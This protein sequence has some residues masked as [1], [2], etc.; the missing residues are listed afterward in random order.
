[1]K[2]HKVDGLFLIS[3]LNRA[4]QVGGEKKHTKKRERKMTGVT[5]Y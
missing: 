5:N 3:F 4:A 2:G 1:M